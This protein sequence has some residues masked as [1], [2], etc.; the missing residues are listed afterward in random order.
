MIFEGTPLALWSVIDADEHVSSVM[1]KFEIEIITATSPAEIEAAR[2]LLREYITWVLTLDAHAATAPTFKGIEEE[3]ATLPG[4][5]APPSGRLL[6]A[7]H[8]GQAVGCVCLKSVDHETSEVKR[9]YVSPAMRGRSIGNQ[10]VAK[11]VEEA[12]RC[13][14]R[15]IVLDTHQSMTKAHAIYESAGFKRVPP[16]SEVPDYVKEVAIFMECNLI[17]REHARS[18]IG[19]VASMG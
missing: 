15:Q 18:D 10:L 2:N 14:Y 1:D 17:A 6:V 7:M 9:L 5:Y 19:A 12:H 11:L 16:P 4:I 3:L 13:G 8:Q